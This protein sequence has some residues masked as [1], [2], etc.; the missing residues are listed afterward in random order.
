MLGE[1]KEWDEQVDLKVYLCFHWNV[2]MQND[3]KSQPL[4]YKCTCLSDVMTIEYKH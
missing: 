2:N 4:M 3:L 1:V